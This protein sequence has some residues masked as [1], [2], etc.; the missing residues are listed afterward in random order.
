[1]S[2][3]VGYQLENKSSISS[4]VIPLVS[5]IMKKQVIPTNILIQECIKNIPWV[6]RKNSNE[7]TILALKNKLKLSSKPI[8]AQPNDLAFRGRISLCKMKGIFAT[9]NTN[10]TYSNKMAKIGIIRNEI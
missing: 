9:P 6:P 10:A 4:K 7:G 5:G 2:Y 8:R 1:M 3:I